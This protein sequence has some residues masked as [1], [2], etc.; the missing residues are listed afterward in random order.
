M[1]VKTAIEIRFEGLPERPNHHELTVTLEDK[2]QD[3]VLSALAEVFDTG[4][5]GVDF[6]V[7]ISELR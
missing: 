5:K 6:Q 3:A 7:R 4:P 1:N 2:I